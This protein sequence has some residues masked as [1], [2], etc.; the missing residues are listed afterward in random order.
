MKKLLLTLLIFALGLTGCTPAIF[1]TNYVFHYAL[2]KWPD[3]TIKKIGIM[4]WFEYK[5]E[6][7]QIISTD[8]NTY[9]LSMNNTVLVREKVK[10]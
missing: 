1:D 3:G 8:G 2:T 9:L 6:Q 10:K 4:T 7:V 5:G